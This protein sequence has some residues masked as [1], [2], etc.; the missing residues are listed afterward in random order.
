MAGR[1]SPGDITYVL[2]SYYIMHAYLRDVGMHIN[3]LQ[4]SLNDME[5]LVDIYD[6]PFGRGSAAGNGPGGAPVDDRSES[7]STSV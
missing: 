6:E 4:R 7:P 3:N 2:T 1:A 5:E